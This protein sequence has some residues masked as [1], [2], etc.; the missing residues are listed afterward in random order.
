MLYMFSLGCV[1][2]SS[3]SSDFMSW[4]WWTTHWLVIQ[5]WCVK[6]CLFQS[7]K[8]HARLYNL[9]FLTNFTMDNGNGDQSKEKSKSLKL[10][11]NK[12]TQ[13]CKTICTLQRL[14]ISM[15]FQRFICYKS[16]TIFN[17]II[18]DTT[19]PKNMDKILTSFGAFDESIW[20]IK[21]KMSMFL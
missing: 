5:M 2:S 13:N 12:I 3:L 4:R 9:N 14:I 19:I 10:L 20:C 1:T 18:I 7:S 15:D 21:K 6:L 16:K 17:K 11:W 8:R